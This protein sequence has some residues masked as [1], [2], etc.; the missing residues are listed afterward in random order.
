LTQPLRYSPGALAPD[1]L[2]AGAGVLVCGM[3]ASVVDVDSWAFIVFIGL[4]VVFA[5][6]GALTLHRGRLRILVSADD[7]LAHPGAQCL[8]WAALCGFTL[9][10]YSTRRDREGGWMQLTLTDADGV[11]LRV[12]SR[13]TGFSELVARAVGAALDNS[14]QMTPTTLEN[15]ESLGIPLSSARA[16]ER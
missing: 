3:I 5:G 4:A 13:L 14:V 9:D 10:Y 7:V 8:R 11:R 15:L 1:L 16:G 12:D 2:R 6:F